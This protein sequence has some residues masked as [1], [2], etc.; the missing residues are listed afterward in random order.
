MTF[1]CATLTN[2]MRFKLTKFAHSEAVAGESVELTLSELAELLTTKPTVNTGRKEAGA[3][4]T[5]GWYEGSTRAAGTP[6]LGAS[7]FVLDFDG[8]K[9]GAGLSDDEIESILRFLESQ[10]L[11]HILYSTYTAGRL[12]VVLPL[13]REVSS[14]EYKTLFDVIRKA[15]PVAP[16]K[17]GRTALRLHFFPQV[18][19]ADAAAAHLSHA[20][21][22]GRLLDPAA[23]LITE[24]AVQKPGFFSD[25]LRGISKVVIGEDIR[26]LE[27]LT[28]V[29]S[30]TSTK[31]DRLWMAARDLGVI[32]AQKG[33][34]KQQFALDFWAAAQAGLEANPSSVENWK[35]ALETVEAKIEWAYAKVASDRAA[36][37]EDI[38]V[39]V[40][41]NVK[42]LINEGN[43]SAAGKVLG[44]YVND[45][46]TPEVLSSNLTEAIEASEGV[47]SIPDAVAELKTALEASARFEWQT[48]LYLD[49]KGNFA[50]NDANVD[51][52][53]REHPEIRG[54]ILKDVRS[55]HGR[56][57]AD[58]MPW[59]TGPGEVENPASDERNFFQWLL[60]ELTQ[61]KS[62]SAAGM[63]ARRAEERLRAAFDAAPQTDPFAHWLTEL[64][65]DGRKR[66]DT[67]LSAYCGAENNE[68][69][70]AVGRKWLIGACARTFQPGC[71]MDNALVFVSPQQGVGKSTAILSVLPNPDSWGGTIRLDEKE[72]P[73]KM[74]RYVIGVVEEIDK[75]SSKKAASE[76]KEFVT[77]RVRQY[78]P[79]YGRT[80]LPFPRRAVLLGTSNHEDFLHDETGARRWWAVTITQIDRE[81]LAL[82]RDQLWAEAVQAYVANERWW[83]TP[84]EQDRIAAPQQTA[85]T[86]RE[87]SPEAEHLCA[88]MAY[89]PPAVRYAGAS[90]PLT[91]E[92]KIPEWPGQVENDKLLWVT[93]RQVAI[94]LKNGDFRN[95]DKT[96]KDALKRAGLKRNKA[97]DRYSLCGTL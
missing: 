8:P 53:L 40:V 79:A 11:V 45:V 86:T 95:D 72:L 7:C 74:S 39:S 84:A 76:M 51:H 81:R 71:Q 92:G 38:P 49:E 93:L 55:I 80:E 82:D 48:A 22:S 75:L 97:N 21:T 29:L 85:L 20:H 3:A 61:G 62:T 1:D 15:L 67:W 50:G 34:D 69:T 89:C 96:V 90:K 58:D 54:L 17:S 73:A 35:S 30:R 5:P 12:R 32:A 9:K 23:P 42:K 44:K 60:R 28:R 83:F 37:A 14:D 33:I 63:P 56:A 36:A 70:R 31:H 52:I 66:L 2:T 47:V 10:D 68:Y 4:F 91:T 78:R 41:K 16:D 87:S 27:D 59:G 18:P 25:A 94:I 26:D 6:F 77:E 88:A 13:S 24:S 64:Q 43:V 65:W 46:L 19:T 57:Y